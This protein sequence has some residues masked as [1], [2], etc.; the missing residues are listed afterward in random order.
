MLDTPCSEVVWRVLTPTPFASFPFTSPPMRHR[1]PSHFSWTLQIHCNAKHLKWRILISAICLSFALIKQSVIFLYAVVA[2]KSW[3]LHPV[4]SNSSVPT[5]VQKSTSIISVSLDRFSAKG[6]WHS[7][8]KLWVLVQLHLWC[9]RCCP[10]WYLW[11]INPVECWRSYRLTENQNQACIWKFSKPS[12]N[13][14]CFN[15]G[16]FEEF[17]SQVLVST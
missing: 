8:L 12:R 14:V 4:L 13:P 10:C 5:G 3:V 2:R 17:S 11:H 9:G 6:N 7:C 15:K 1:V 16:L